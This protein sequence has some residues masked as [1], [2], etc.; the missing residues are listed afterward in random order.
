MTEIIDHAAA[1]A[2]KSAAL[3]ALASRVIQT[4]SNRRKRLTR[5]VEYATRRRANGSN[6][7]GQPVVPGSAVAEKCR[8]RVQGPQRKRRNRRRGPGDSGGG[9]YPVLP[10]ETCRRST[11]P[12]VGA[13]VFSHDRA[14]AD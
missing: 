14:R 4:S 12:L 11:G 1:H 8:L 7:T 3:Q 2:H 13:G 5:R 10:S 6:A 9:G